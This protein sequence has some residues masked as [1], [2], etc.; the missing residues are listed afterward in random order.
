M[1]GNPWKLAKSLFGKDWRRGQTDWHTSIDSKSKRFMT[2]SEMRID[3]SDKDSE[4]ETEVESSAIKG[5][6][7]NP[8]THSLFITYTNGDKEYEFPNVPE[9]I[10][11]ELDNAPSKGRFV[12][13]VIKPNYS[14]NR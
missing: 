3:S 11:K 4:I 10:V 12:Q 13:F 7:W 8:E 14:I 9:S 5:Y 1:T 6:T 2:P